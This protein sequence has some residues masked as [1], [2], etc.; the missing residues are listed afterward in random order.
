MSDCTE[1]K[2]KIK[3]QSALEYVRE[4]KI[5]KEKVLPPTKVTEPIRECE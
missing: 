1:S 4:L 5:E 3:K 2:K